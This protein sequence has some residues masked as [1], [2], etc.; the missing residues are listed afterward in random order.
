[1]DDITPLVDSLAPSAP[2]V[3][4]P[5]PQNTA[6]GRDTAEPEDL[7]YRSVPLTV[8]GRRQ[9][10]YRHVGTLRPMSYEYDEDAE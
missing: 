4:V 9:V 2:L 6:I 3:E 8:V 10:R 7:S 1:M 5:A